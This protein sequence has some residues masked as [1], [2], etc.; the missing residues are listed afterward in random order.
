MNIDDLGFELIKN[1]IKQVK[2]SFHEG[3]WHVEYRKP[4]KG[5]FGFYLKRH[6]FHDSKYSNYADAHV[7]AE[8]LAA[9]GYYETY[10][11]KFHIYDVKGE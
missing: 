6:W 9:T 10:E 5:L 7:R 1:P 3:K 4:S 2:C 8:F 11:K